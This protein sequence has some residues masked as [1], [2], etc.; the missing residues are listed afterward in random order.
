[1]GL[2]LVWFD[3]HLHIESYPFGLL[4]LETQQPYDKSPISHM[5]G[6]QKGGDTQLPS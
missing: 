5:G 4:L 3:R 1:M 6:T 2:S